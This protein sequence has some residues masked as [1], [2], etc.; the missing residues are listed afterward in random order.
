[1]NSTFHK[2][3]DYHGLKMFDNRSVGDYR[4]INHAGFAFD[5]KHLIVDGEYYK[6]EQE[7]RVEG[8]DGSFRWHQFLTITYSGLLVVF[9]HGILKFILDTLPFLRALYNRSFLIFKI[10]TD[11][12]TTYGFIFAMI[13][14]N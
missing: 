11:M 4:V 8:I 7:E 1:M 12:M 9:H 14:F 10:Q 2:Y 6:A 13:C 3:I 5:L